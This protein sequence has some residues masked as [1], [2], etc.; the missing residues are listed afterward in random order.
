MFSKLACSEFL[1]HTFKLY[2]HDSY[3]TV[4]LSKVRMGI[5]IVHEYFKQM[6]FSKF[7][8]IAERVLGIIFKTKQ[9]TTKQML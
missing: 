5:Y 3:A 1:I 7:W 9:A 8:E 4:P 6:H 2:E